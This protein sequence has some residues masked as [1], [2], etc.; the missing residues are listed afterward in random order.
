M[1]VARVDST[2]GAA[3]GH[4]P[5][6]PEST[7]KKSNFRACFNGPSGAVSWIVR[8]AGH[9]PINRGKST[10]MEPDRRAAKKLPT[11]PSCGNRLRLRA[12]QV[13]TQVS[14]PKCNSTFMV[15]RPGAV[16]HAPA[17]PAGASASTADL[18][19]PI[20]D[21]AYEPEVPLV[22][23]TIVPQEE[24]SDIG[25]LG[26]GESQYDVDWSVADDLEAEAPH[27]PPPSAEPDYLALAKAKGIV[28]DLYVPDPP[29]WTFFSGVFTYPWEGINLARWTVMS[30]GLSATGMMFWQTATLMGLFGDG[31]LREAILGVASGTTTIAIAL[32]ALS[33]CAATVMAAIQ[34]TADGHAV[35]QESSVPDWDQWIFSFVNLFCLWAASAALGYPLTLIEPIGPAACLI[36]SMILFPILLLSA[37]E[38]D[39]FFFPYSPNVL[40][41]ADP[42]LV[43][44]VHVLSAHGR[45]ARGL[46]VAARG[47]TE[48]D[49]VPGDARFRAGPGGLDAHLCPAVGASGLEGIGSAHDCARGF[50]RWKTCGQAAQ[51]R[52]SGGSGFTLKCPTSW[53]PLPSWAGDESLPRERI[54]FHHRS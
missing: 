18:T 39:S 8:W 36:S 16:S 6:Q 54:T 32:A 3:L 20:D 14:C 27:K 43:R 9:V 48:G 42:L 52:R 50:G 47:R 24:M 11:C 38:A 5:Q 23:Y 34:D 49:A 28:R 10:P 25:P 37:M 15:Q 17:K 1:Y 35:P 29:T 30:I 44:V 51:A 7:R 46:V 19:S 12:D 2:S 26:G 40:A 45:D 31:L 4:P 21:D 13:G 22:R 41:T 33:Y 53:T